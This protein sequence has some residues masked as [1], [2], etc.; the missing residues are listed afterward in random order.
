MCG[1]L[2]CNS[3]RHVFRT[4]RPPTIAEPLH[5]AQ[6]GITASPTSN[7]VGGVHAL[8]LSKVNQRR[9]V[10]VRTQRSSFGFPHLAQRPDAGRIAG[11]SAAIA[12]H[13]LALMVLLAPMSPPPVT[14]LEDRHTPPDLPRTPVTPPPRPE[15]V[16]VVRNAAPR[17]QTAVQ[18]RQSATPVIDNEVIVDNG[19]IAVETATIST[20]TIDAGSV[21]SM[22]LAGAYLEYA[23]APPPVYPRAALRDRLTGTVMLEVLVDIDGRPLDVKIAQSSGHREL[24]RAALEHVLKRWTF[25]PAMKNGQAVQ[26][27]GLVPIAFNLR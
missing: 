10:M 9:W 8:F 2:F 25:R 26:A 17:P 3:I 19:N 6:R 23:N 14:A 1:S 13:V 16:P 21:V 24:D 5:P 20:E 15:P 27:T 22:P 12:I 18:P 7:P 4:G 11:I